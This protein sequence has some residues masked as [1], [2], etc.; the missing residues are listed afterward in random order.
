[1]LTCNN[2]IL[3]PAH[4]VFPRCSGPKTNSPEMIGKLREAGVNVGKCLCRG[5]YSVTL[6]IR[7]QSE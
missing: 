2:E 3:L 4:R 1:M 5:I 7:L 6:L